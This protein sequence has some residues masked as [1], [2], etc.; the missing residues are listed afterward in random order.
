MLKNGAQAKSIKYKAYQSELP[1]AEALSKF[2]SAMEIKSN[3]EIDQTENL[4]GTSN[5][6]DRNFN[7]SIKVGKRFSSGTELSAE[8]GRLQ[9][10][11]ILSTFS[12]SLR[13][14]KQNQSALYV[15]LKQNLLN[16]AFGKVDRNQVKVAKA[17]KEQAY[18]AQDESLENLILNTLVLYWNTYIAKQNLQESI[19]ARKLIQDLVNTVEKKSRMGYAAPGELARVM[20]EYELQDQRVK[21]ISSNYLSLLSKLKVNLSIEGDIELKAVEELPK[22]PVHKPIELENQRLLKIALSEIETSKLNLSS[23]KSKSFPILNLDFSFSSLGVEEK[24]DKAFTEMSSFSKPSYFLGLTLQ[25]FLDSSAQ[26]INVSTKKIKLKDSELSYRFIKSQ[27][28]SEIKSKYNQLIS[29]FKIYQ[30]SIK[31]LN[32][33]DKALKQMK[34]AYNQGRLDID[35]LIQAYRD[36]FSAQ[37][38][39]IQAI[40]NYYVNLHDYAASK[41]ELIT[42]EQIK[43][44]LGKSL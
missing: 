34:T 40:A 23:A 27:I 43:G 11:S 21:N 32:L 28:N 15:N 44:S 10:K 37:V 5:L 9:Q 3:Y 18:L 13:P 33:R 24:A 22:L 38:S 4:V 16:N 1:Y 17:Q 42:E 12:S 8:Y 35:I 41:D 31:M 26:G 30:S 20:A 29:S 25:F 6:E 36:K 14:D 19:E 2:D 39:N 7:S